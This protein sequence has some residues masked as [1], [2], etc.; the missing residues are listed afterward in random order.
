[1]AVLG[2]FGTRVLV[3]RPIAREIAALDRLRWHLGLTGLAV[4][5][6]GLAGGWL[7]S[8]RAVRPIRAM[9]ATAAAI[10]VCNLSRRIDLAGVDS[11]L[12]ELAEILNAMFTRLEAAF[13]RQARFTADASHEL[14][15]P[16]AVIH[17]HA[18]LALARPRPAEDY[19]EALETCLRASG[20]MRALVEGLL[21]L[22]RADAGTLE[23]RRERVDLGAVAGES[24]ALAAPLARQMQ[25]GLAVEAR[26]VEVTGDPGRLAQVV[27]NLLANAINYNH[28]GGE[29]SVT[30]QAAGAEA[31]L[32]VA[33]TGYGIPEE[34]RAHIFERFYRVDK[35][36]SRALGGSG[37][38]L[39][40]C[41]SIVEAHHGTITFTTE[42]N[43][44]T[45]FFVRLP[46]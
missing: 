29:V 20:R 40:I 12:G 30:L 41:K 7:L 45:T 24:A 46:L 10:S 28:P 14:R 44:G 16:L 19:R 21:T 31:V 43:C 4:L 42:L 34:D 23:V 17:S 35:A 26:R 5:A 9:S 22:A 32:A 25:V 8:A 3:G 39:A 6:V 15:T 36:R 2:P 38:G 27:T 33:D 13:D 37:L 1:V 18:E 11:E